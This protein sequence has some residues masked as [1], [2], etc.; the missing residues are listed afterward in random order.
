MLRLRNRILNRF[1]QI[2]QATK[3]KKKVITKKPRGKLDE[4]KKRS[5]GKTLRVVPK[6]TISSV[7]KVA[8]S[9]KNSPLRKTSKPASPISK[10]I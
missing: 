3:N 10:Q 5:M 6:R 1:K 4:S 8:L 9:G 2:K 7:A